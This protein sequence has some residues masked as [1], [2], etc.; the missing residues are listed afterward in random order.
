[1]ASSDVN[2]TPTENEIKLNHLALQ[3][4]PVM[5]KEDG[6]LGGEADAVATDRLP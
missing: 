6:N 1:M 2:T 5:F 4:R 3:I